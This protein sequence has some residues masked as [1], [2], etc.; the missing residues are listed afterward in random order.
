[1]LIGV[2]ASICGG[3]LLVRRLSGS[4]QSTPGPEA[5]L[6]ACGAGL[7]L[8]AV[9]DLMSRPAAAR[10]GATGPW[11]PP[12]LAR[13]GL[14]LA[15]AAVSL[16]LRFTSTIDSLIA[17][18]ALGIA[19][20]AAIRGPA[21][22]VISSWLTHGQLS[23]RHGRAAL[24]PAIESPSRPLS[25]APPPLLTAHEPDLTAALAGSLLQRYERVALPDGTECVRGRLCLVVPQGARTGSA[26]FGFCPPL[27][28]VP[29]VNVTTDYDGV[30]AVVSA[31]EVLPWGVRIECRLDEPAEEPIEIPVDILAK[32][33]A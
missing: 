2:M 14:L 33:G 30:E 22:D 18:A 15:V 21:A 9:S 7:L 5:V 10:E 24:A 29:T 17:L 27:P 25:I 13:L 19:V 26:H 32:T 1:M 4:I 28:A 20:V 11:L 16:P 3:V 6:A 8:V 31:A 12:V 23:M